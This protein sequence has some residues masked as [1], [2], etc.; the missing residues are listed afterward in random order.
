MTLYQKQANS[1]LTEQINIRL[2]KR[3]KEELME[4]CAE[5]GTTISQYV[6]FLIV[7]RLNDDK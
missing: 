4:L 6:R 2:S 1:D 7:K 3:Q 5:Q